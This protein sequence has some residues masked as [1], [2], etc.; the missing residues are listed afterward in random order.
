ML[1]EGLF[2]ENKYTKWYT[3]IILKAKARENKDDGYRERHHIIPK[4]FYLKNR[5]KQSRNG[6]LLGNCDD[7]S[8]I[9]SLT[10]R[11]HFVIHWLLTKMVPIRSKYWFSLNYALSSFS[12]SRNEDRSFT[13]RQYQICREALAAARKGSIT[14]DHTKHLIS[15]KAKDRC[16]DPAYRKKISQG[17]LSRGPVTDETKRRM[18]LA[19]KG[20]NKSKSHS[21]NISKGIK[22]Y[23]KDPKNRE[24]RSEQ[25]KITNARPEVKKKI[26]DG[27]RG[28]LHSVETKESMSKIALD[29]CKDP[30]YL[31][32]QST[33]Q[34][35]RW[36][37]DPQVWWN[38]GIKNTRKS[39]CPG[40]DWIPGRIG[41]SN[42]D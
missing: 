40:S 26:S 18:S 20:K 42:K 30:I 13:S 38:N 35:E 29:R 19:S 25:S 32:K 7:H 3:N 36:L 15:Q 2:L 28:I 24:K 23:F 31:E 33:S 41:W 14:S 37:R 12:M 16:S 5:S 27:R 11:E 34:K 8:N 1:P 6:H 4:C 9:V 39:S 10:A 17:Q 22:E 21:E